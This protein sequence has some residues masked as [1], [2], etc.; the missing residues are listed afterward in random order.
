MAVDVDQ[1]TRL[2]RYA[3]LAVRIGSNVEEGQ[4]V[5]IG[6]LVEHAELARALARAAYEAGARY[7]EVFYRD[8]HVRRAMIEG[9]PEETLSWTP[10]WL[11]ERMRELGDG[12]SAQIAVS[13]DPEPDLLADL[14]PKRVG[15][16]YMR[17]LAELNL[18]Y[19]VQRANNWT[20]VA[21]P[22][23]GWAEKVFGEPDVERL[24]EAVSYA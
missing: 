10:P 18:K 2:E 21:M 14:D 17:D 8:A 23:E 12:R 15:Q 3:E 19:T 16:A 20:I 9:A 6:A 11:L 5:V 1:K 7:V 22:N 24:W 13:G 4:I